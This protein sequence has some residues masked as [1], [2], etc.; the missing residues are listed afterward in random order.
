MNAKSHQKLP[1]VT[2]SYQ[3]AA[4][5]LPKVAKNLS[6]SSETFGSERAC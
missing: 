6:A 1:K 5:K 4:K 2:K 3:K